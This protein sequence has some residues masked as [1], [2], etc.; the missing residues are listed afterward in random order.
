MDLTKLNSIK[1]VPAKEIFAKSED[2]KT[3]V[4][5]DGTKVSDELIAKAKTEKKAQAAAASAASEA[6]ASAPAG[7]SLEELDQR[8]A[9]AVEAAVKKAT[10]G[11][12]GD[13]GK[14]KDK[15]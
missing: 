12:G 1:D 2:G 7:I 14:E 5:N 15:K 10:A 3:V 13:S 8:I 6:V 9:K 4:T 11:T